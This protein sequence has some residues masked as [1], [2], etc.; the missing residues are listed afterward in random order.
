MFRILG[1]IC[2]LLF[3]GVGAHAQTAAEI[4]QARDEIWALEKKIYMGRAT[5]GLEFYLANTS[6][7]FVGWPPQA[8]KPLDYAGL[9]ASSKDLEGQN[10]EKLTME[11]TGFTMQGD[12]GVI[13]YQT[14]RTMLPN[15]TA[16]DE[17]FEVIHVWIREKG[18]WK[19]FGAMARATPKR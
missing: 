10:R 9:K 13:Y 6:S 11:L 3:T 12:T 7:A 18:A 4:A 16:V 19:V 8:A 1:V 14:H 5:N 17:R 15:G 2:S